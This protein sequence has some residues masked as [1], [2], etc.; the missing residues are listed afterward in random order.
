MGV[1]GPLRLPKHLRSVADE[2]PDTVADQTLP[3]APTKPDG[4]PD[5][6][7]AAWD[8]IVDALDECGLLSRADGAT[9]ELAVRHYVTAVKASNIVLRD[10][11]VSVPDK[12]HGG[13]KKHPAEAVFRSESDM[14]LRYAQQLGMTFVSRARTTAPKADS[15]GDGNP[16]TVEASSG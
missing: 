8:L 5:E 9:V 14:F 1:S 2:A 10:D 15:G 16:F 4:L 11:D 6:V 3:Q 13:L 12:T 7:S